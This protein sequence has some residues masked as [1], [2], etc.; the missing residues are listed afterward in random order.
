MFMTNI[1]SGHPGGGAKVEK[2][3]I[4]VMDKHIYSS[5]MATSLFL[6]SQEPGER[7]M[8]WGRRTA[9]QFA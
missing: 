5:A 3:G 6:S 8:F 9:H 1:V 7:F 4:E 2:L